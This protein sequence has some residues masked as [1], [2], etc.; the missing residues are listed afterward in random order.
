M[1]GSCIAELNLCME[2]TFKS[3]AIITL[4]LAGVKRRRS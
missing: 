2:I 1:L 4:I 3:F